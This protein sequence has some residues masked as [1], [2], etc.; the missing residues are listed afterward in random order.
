MRRINLLPPEERRR[1]VALQAPGGILG[2]LLIVG[3]AVLL[4]M[5]G[6]YVFYMVRLNNQEEQ[7][8]QLDQQITEQNARIAELSPFRELQA[9]LD[10]KKPVADGIF[11]SRFPWDEFLQGLAFV[12]P[13]T[14]ALD[15]LTAQAAPID[16]DAPVEQPLSPPGTVAF[17][18]IASP[19]DYQ[20]ISDFIVSMNSLR[21]LS[22]SQLTSADL[23][24]ETFPDPV[25][26]FESVSELIT[27][28]GQSGTEV[29]IEGPEP[30]EEPAAIEGDPASQSQYGGLP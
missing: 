5:V 25:L 11:R 23:D 2:T 24:R 27:V 9:R 14:A 15:T 22:N 19:A 28:V 8:A 1:G 20:N 10:A 21:F 30:T 18:G 4:V 16:I 3:A 6:V 29:R 7:I 26:N 12:I 17:T 13:P